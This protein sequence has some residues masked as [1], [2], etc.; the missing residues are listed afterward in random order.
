MKPSIRVTSRL[1]HTFDAMLDILAGISGAFYLFLLGSVTVAVLSRNIFTKPMAW[2]I[3]LSEYILLYTTFLGAAWILRSD[4]HVKVDILVNR[5]R[6]T[7]RGR[8]KFLSIAIE[9][10]VSAVLLYFGACTTVE[11][12][13]KHTPVIKVMA[14]PKFLIVGIIPF[15]S[16]FLLIQSIRSLIDHTRQFLRPKQDRRSSTAKGA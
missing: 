5:L 10:F 1:G 13:V 2:T 9:I 4:S 16:L 15:G 6:P 14:V 7:Q 12:F 8:I 3:E 11:L